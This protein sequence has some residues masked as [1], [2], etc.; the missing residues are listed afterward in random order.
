MVLHALELRGERW[1]LVRGMI[2]GT[3]RL[4]DSDL[5]LEGSMVTGMVSLEGTSRLL[6]RGG[7]ITGSVSKSASSTFSNQGGMLTGQ[8]YNT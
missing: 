1:R 3:V 5:V 6:L 4:V 2:T 8:V 7:M